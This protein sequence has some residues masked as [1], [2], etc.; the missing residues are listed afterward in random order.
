MNL[1]EIQEEKYEP[2]TSNKYYYANISNYE[3]NFQNKNMRTR[4]NM[5]T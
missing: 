4:T 1:M 3:S 5:R 2:N